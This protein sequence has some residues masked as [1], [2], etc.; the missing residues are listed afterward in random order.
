MELKTFV[1]LNGNFC[2]IC[3]FYR[4]QNV[5]SKT[6]IQCATTFCIK[7][8]LSENIAIKQTFKLPLPV[9]FSYL[10]SIE[11]YIDS[12]RITSFVQCHCIIKVGVK[13]K[14]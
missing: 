14:K 3:S 8:C 6:K 13:T 7:K 10:P 5:A 1:T 2:N 11:I 4:E 9:K 12:S